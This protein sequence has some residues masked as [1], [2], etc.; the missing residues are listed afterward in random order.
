M[1]RNELF[2]KNDTEKVGGMENNVYLC[3][4]KTTFVLLTKQTQKRL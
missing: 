3:K 2:S 4:N 1:A